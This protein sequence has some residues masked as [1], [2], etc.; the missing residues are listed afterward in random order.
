MNFHRT[1]T[2][3]EQFRQHWGGLHNFL[4]GGDISADFDYP[5]PPLERIIDE[6]RQAPD[7]IV[8]GGV[9]SDVFDLTDIKA[10]FIRQPLAE[11]LQR[12]FVLAHFRLHP[13]LSGRG[14]VFEG[15]DKRWVEP[16]RRKLREHGF[17]FGSVF[18]ILFASGPNSASNYHLDITHQLAW[19]RYGTKH[20]T[21]L[22][23]PDRW[24]TREQ[25]GRCELKGT[26]KPDGITAADVY[27]IEQ[28]P[29]SLLWN[30][31]TT[32]HWVE[33]FDACAVTLT[34]VHQELRLNG[35]FCP[36]AAD[37]ERWRTENAWPPKVATGGKSSY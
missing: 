21:G 14:Q 8:R 5:L 30:A 37:C 22:K 12:R 31:H 15:I 27:T 28:P 19:Q 34:L 33:T 10:E 11:A 16:W 7:A 23:D 9:K 35:Q 4:L 26:V 24:T 36:H 3:W 18:A 17:E 32:P 13:C 2:D 20:F 29:G 6:V 25:R 1:V